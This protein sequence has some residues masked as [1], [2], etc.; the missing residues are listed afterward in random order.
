MACIPHVYLVP[1]QSTAMLVLVEFE[2]LQDLEWP[3]LTA[4]VKA[5][6]RSEPGPL[7]KLMSHPSVTVLWNGLDLV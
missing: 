6:V 1:G 5:L 2:V 7:L 4:A 3:A